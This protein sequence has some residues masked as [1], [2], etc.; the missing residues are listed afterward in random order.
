M[1]GKAISL[2]CIA[3]KLGEGGS[4]VVYNAEDTKL[5]RPVALK[6]LPPHLL[7]DDEAKRRFLRGAKAAPSLSHPNICDVYELDEAGSKTFS[8]MEGLVL[9]FLFPASASRF[10]CAPASRLFRNEE[11]PQVWEKRP[12]PRYGTCGRAAWRRAPPVRPQCFPLCRRV[13]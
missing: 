8:A 4:G 11:G 12:A 3:D 10:A 13:L 7:N 9:P 5:E 1:I 2:Y 6:S